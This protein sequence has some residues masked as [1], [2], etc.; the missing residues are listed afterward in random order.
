[1]MV[2]SFTAALVLWLGFSTSAMAQTPA[3]ETAIRAIIADWYG[4][5][6]KDKENAPYRLLAPMAID[7]GPGVTRL[8][9]N[10]A[11]MGP[12]ISNELAARALTFDYEIDRL[13]IDPN[14]ARVD[15]WERGYFYAWAA[16]STYENAADALFILERQP[17]GRWLILAHEAN[18]VGIPPNRITNPMPDL[19]EHFYATEGKNRS[20]EDDAKNR[21]RF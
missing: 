9:P 3:D 8:C 5:L 13:R 4:N 21:I 16:Q 2:R 7:G 14:F 17:D 19:R 15:V 1:M 18:G 11:A 12:T 10:C 6:T 20:P